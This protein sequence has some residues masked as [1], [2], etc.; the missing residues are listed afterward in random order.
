MKKGQSL[1]E[2]LFAIAFAGITILVLFTG[3]VTSREGKAQESQRLL[4]IPLLRETQEA[5]RV[6]REKNWNTF[7]VNGTY[8][9]VIVSNTWSL[10]SGTETINTFTR[11]ISISDVSPFD[12]ST[13]KVIATV[14]WTTPYSSSVSS[15]TYISRYLGNATWVQTTEV[16][17]NAGTKT[18]VAVANTA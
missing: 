4:A 12:P 18:D 7:A 10:V 17:F 1:I 9:P 16:D 8:H 13:K 14:S 5:V 3:F 11:S 15:T 2:L 6:V